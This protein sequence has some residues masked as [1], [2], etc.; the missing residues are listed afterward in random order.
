MEEVIGSLLLDSS[1][2]TPLLKVFY[3]NPQSLLSPQ[4][5]PWIT[6]DKSSFKSLIQNNLVFS[7]NLILSSLSKNLDKEHHPE[8]RY[9]KDTTKPNMMLVI[10]QYLDLF[11]TLKESN[12]LWLISNIMGMITQQFTRVNKA[13]QGQTAP[14][15]REHLKMTQTISP[16]HYWVIP[17]KWLILAWVS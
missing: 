8:I 2:G 7:R 15:S 17:V 12:T 16:S 13:T 6:Q 3:P 9:S 5:F 1:L 14:I 4:H 11:V 10:W